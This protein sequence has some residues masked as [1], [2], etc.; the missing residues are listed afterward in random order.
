MEAVRG[1]FSSIGEMPI[2]VFFRGAR[3]VFKEDE[4]GMDIMQIAIPATLTLAADPIASLIDTAFIGH[5]GPVEL[6]AVGVSIAV[7]NQVSKI[8]IFPLVSITTSFIA[9]EDSMIPT[10]IDRH[11]YA[12]IFCIWNGL[13]SQ[14]RNGSGN[15]TSVNG[16]SCEKEPRIKSK[17]KHIPSASSAMVIGS[18]L[19]LLQTLSLIITARPMLSYMGV[20]S[21]SPMLKPAKQYLTLRSLGAP[22]V[23]LSL[24]M[25]GIFRGFKDTK[26][27]LYATVVGDAANVILDYA[28]IFVLR[29]G[30][31]GAAIAHVISQEL[32]GTLKVTKER[33]SHHVPLKGAKTS[34]NGIDINWFLLL[35]RVIAVTFCVTLAA[36]LAARHGMTSMAAFQVCL[37]IW[38]AS[39]LLADGLA[40]AGQV[41]NY[42]NNERLSLLVLLQRRITGRSLL[43]LPVYYSCAWFWGLDSWPCSK[44]CYLSHP[45]YS[46]MTTRSY[47]LSG[48]ESRSLR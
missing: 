22:A 9:E 25:Q 48:S 33:C 39:S 47:D 28:F 36:S 44:R 27:P 41:R 26:T 12:S 13:R 19:G 18:V 2:S 5:I 31:T 30:V 17:R 34:T 29:M 6:A 43:P 42:L 7:F 40:I 38:L 3:S 11:K 8:T 16:T 10:R 46:Q 1:L 15:G 4:L 45:D 14:Q 32:L 21:D 37:Q 24:V 20:I 35:V 23:L